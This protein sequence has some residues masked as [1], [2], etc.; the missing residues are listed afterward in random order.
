MSHKMSDTDGRL[1]PRV[2]LSYTAQP[3]YFFFGHF[4]FPG[5]AATLPPGI[6]VL[7][8]LPPIPPLPPWLSYAG[9]G[10]KREGEGRLTK[11]NHLSLRRKEKKDV[12]TKQGSPPGGEGGPVHMKPPVKEKTE[13]RKVPQRN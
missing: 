1:V 2:S 8:T 12:C 10:R 6:V 3:L 11:D 7:S 13:E 9:K 5:G 4:S